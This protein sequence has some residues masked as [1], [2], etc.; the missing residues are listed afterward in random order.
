MS[1]LALVS[2]KVSFKICVLVF[3]VLELL[4]NERTGG[5]NPKLKLDSGLSISF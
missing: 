4:S 3:D 1:E 2:V 5:V